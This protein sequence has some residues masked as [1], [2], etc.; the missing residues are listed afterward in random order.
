MEIKN[1]HSA[2]FNAAL[3]FYR[4]KTFSD[5]LACKNLIVG[6]C[7]GNQNWISNDDDINFSIGGQDLFHSS[8]IVTFLYLYRLKN[9][10]N[11]V[12]FYNFYERVLVNEYTSHFLSSVSMRF[13]WKIP[14]LLSTSYIN[15][16]EYEKM[17]SLNIPV[18]E[19]ISKNFKYDYIPYEREDLSVVTDDFIKRVANF[20][21][22]MFLKHKQLN[23]HI[24][25][26]KIINITYAERIRLFIVLSPHNKLYR[27]HIPD[28]SILFSDLYSLVNRCSHVKV[29][30]LFSAEIFS[31]NDYYDYEHLNKNGAEKLTHIVREVISRSK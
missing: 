12:L 24:W 19:K 28:E 17:L 30:N 25:L 10:K 7:Q 6:M 27:I 14:Y 1:Q 18:L 3:A 11:I 26:Q 22:E 13:F 29:I 8:E 20:H 31:D 5:R 4:I 23:Q 16:T 15:F 9:I 2:L 21:Y